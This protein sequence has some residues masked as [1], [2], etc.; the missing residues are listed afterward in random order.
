MRIVCIECVQCANAFRMVDSH[1]S[2]TTKP[3]ACAAVACLEGIFSSV[4]FT[5]KTQTYVHAPCGIR[6]HDLIVRSV[7]DSARTL[8]PGSITMSPMLMLPFYRLSFDFDPQPRNHSLVL[9]D[10]TGRAAHLC[11]P[12]D[13]AV[14]SVLRRW[15]HETDLYLARF[16][17]GY[18]VSGF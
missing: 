16:V 14:S 18:L 2:Y 1:L 9:S 15:E 10:R 4:D 13:S 6:T 7:G 5:E 11:F 17:S 3:H 12:E 8:I